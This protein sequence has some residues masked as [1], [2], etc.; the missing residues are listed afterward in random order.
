MVGPLTS[1]QIALSFGNSIII[2]LGERQS[3]SESISI[4]QWPINC[5][6]LVLSDW[7]PACM[8]R[9]NEELWVK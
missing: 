5:P 2:S 1:E 6:L 7:G 8:T 9:L 4:V 3:F